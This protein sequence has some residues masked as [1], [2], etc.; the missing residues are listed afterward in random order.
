MALSDHLREL[1]ARI[2]RV[3]FVIV[4]A[5]VVACSSSTRCS[6]WSSIPTS[7]RR[8]R[9]PRGRPQPPPA[10]A[11]G[12]FL[13]YLKLCGLAAL[14]GTSPLWLYQIWAFILPGL[15]PNEKKWPRI[16]VAVAGPL[17]FFGIFLGYVTLPKGLEI[18]IGLNAGTSSPT[19]SS[20][21]ST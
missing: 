1:R 8:R 11:G 6:S 19:W 5:F 18:L 17:F 12:G 16:F 10:G 4:A 20:S 3:A 21:T 14:I 9:C 7:R 15:H 2:L 13:L